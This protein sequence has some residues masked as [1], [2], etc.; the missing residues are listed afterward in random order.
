MSGAKEN[1]GRKLVDLIPGPGG[2]FYGLGSDGSL[3]SAFEERIAGP[4]DN[5]RMVW[6][7][8]RGPFDDNSRETSEAK[9]R[10]LSVD[11]TR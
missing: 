3:W 1:L 9:V 8:L 5:S 10:N 4:G 6:R 2:R 7:Q 11:P